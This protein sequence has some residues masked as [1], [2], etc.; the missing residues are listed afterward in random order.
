MK[1]EITSEKIVKFLEDN[2][3]SFVVPG[4]Y[5]LSGNLVAKALNEFI[6]NGSSDLI[7]KHKEYTYCLWEWGKEDGYLDC[8]RLKNFKKLLSFFNNNEIDIKDIDHRIEKQKK[9][10]KRN[11]K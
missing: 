7:S 10:E 2:D 4:C 11:N 6:D 5:G 1:K 3:V 9:Y 8:D